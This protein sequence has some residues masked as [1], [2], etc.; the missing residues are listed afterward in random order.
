MPRR[1]ALLALPLAALLATAPTTLTSTASAAPERDERAADVVLEGRGF[2]HGKGLSQYGARA[3]A[4]QGRTHQEILDFYYPGTQR[5]GVAG[6]VEV[7]ISADTTTD[8]K[9]RPARGLRVRSVATGRSRWLARL[10]P[11]ARAWRITSATRGRSNVEAKVKGGWSRVRTLAGDAELLAKEPLTLLLPRGARATYRGALRS[12]STGAG[13]DRDTVNVVDFEDYLRGV[14]PGEVPAL[15]PTEAVRAQAVAA[16]TYA[17]YERDHAPAARHYELC[18]TSACQVYRGVDAEHPGSDA[19]VAATV[20]V[21]VTADGAP[22]FTQ[23]SASN[24]GWTRAGSFPYLQAV[25]DPWDTAPE[26][27]NPYAQWSRTL[28]PAVLEKVWPGSGS[29]VSLEVVARDGNG[30]WGGRVVRVEVTFTGAT[31]SATGDQFRS[32]LGLRSDWFR[33]QP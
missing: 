33:P 4:A 31:R 32:W 20:G 13:R 21:V 17:A 23:F 11:D 12:A 5:G 10:A 8:V 16:R 2:G 7:L 29:F 18:D 27:Q 3:A 15:W 9:V 28:T 19:A 14:V 26:A 25:E 1:T 24:G 6:D 22:A 30:A